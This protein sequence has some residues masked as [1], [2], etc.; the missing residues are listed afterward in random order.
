M[1][2]DEF[3]TRWRGA[4]FQVRLHCFAFGPEGF[5][6]LYRFAGSARDR[7]VSRDL[8]LSSGWHALEKLE[9]WAAS[10]CLSTRGTRFR[11]A[12]S[13]LQE[14]RVRRAAEKL[15]GHG[16]RD[17]KPN[18]SGT[19]MPRAARK[20]RGVEVCLSPSALARLDESAGRAGLS[21]SAMLEVMIVSYS[22][23]W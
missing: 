23:P 7:P 3:V 10:G 14:L 18:A 4:E 6:W 17:H 15:S 13:A 16:L 21:R 9:F 19:V 2:S 5:G 12:G 22:F 1:R 11:S 8:Y 20:R